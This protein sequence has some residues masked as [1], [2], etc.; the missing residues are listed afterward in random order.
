M[1]SISKILIA[2]TM[3]LSTAACTAQIK[4]AIT[5]TVKVYG[6]CGMCETTIE[7]AGKLKNVSKVDWNKD[8]KMA[9]ITYDAGKTN[10]DAI[11]KKIALAGYDSDNYLAPDAVYNKLPGCCQ[12]DRASKPA[13]SAKL[14]MPKVEDKLTPT[15]TANNAENMLQPVYNAYFALKDALVKTDNNLANAK[16]KDLLMAITAVKMEKLTTAAHNV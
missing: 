3:V 9:T 7:K 8:T 4:N 2:L 5:E 1:K 10:K 12:Y 15:T 14:E 16:G 13:V 11:L 6:N